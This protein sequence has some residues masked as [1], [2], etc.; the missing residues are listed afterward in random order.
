MAD[1]CDRAPPSPNTLDAYKLAAA[2]TN[3]STSPP[4]ISGGTFVSLNGTSTTG[5]ATA[6]GTGSGSVASST[7]SSK[8]GSS[9][10]GSNGSNGIVS[11]TGA[12]TKASSA[13]TAV[14]GVAALG[15]F[16]LM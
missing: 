11:F 1:Y 5:G 16:A 4:T 2:K 6:S 3:I 13:I 15:F 9:F 10:G 8:G 12:A 14:L 7:G